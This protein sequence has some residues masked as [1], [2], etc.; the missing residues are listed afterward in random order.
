[1]VAK[2]TR[3]SK[4]GQ[5][6]ASMAA[7]T[8]HGALIGKK[9][10]EPA[11]I[12]Q[13]TSEIGATP[14]RDAAAATNVVAASPTDESRP[15]RPPTTPTCSCFPPPRMSSTEP[16]PGSASTRSVRGG[17][18]GGCRPASAAVTSTGAVYW[19]KIATATPASRS[20]T[21]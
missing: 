21:K 4:E 11:A 20:A 8:D 1:T 9:A 12:P 13:A 17:G 14:R 7:I 3:Q 15:A 2:R 19:K 5:R 16:A 6:F 18:E 10:S